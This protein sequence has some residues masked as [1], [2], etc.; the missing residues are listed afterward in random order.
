MPVALYHYGA[1]PVTAM[2]VAHTA[3]NGISQRFQPRQRAAAGKASYSDIKRQRQERATRPPVT[4]LTRDGKA[5]CYAASA[6]GM[7]QRLHEERQGRGRCRAGNEEGSNK[8]LVRR[9][10]TPEYA[11]VRQRARHT[12]QPL[13]H[14]IWAL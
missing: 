14:V 8:K 2:P 3:P 10:C 9:D 7:R 1:A 4:P 13:R 11:Y 6:A 12:P 5:H